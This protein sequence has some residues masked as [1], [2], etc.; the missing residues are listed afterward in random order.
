MLKFKW[1][2]WLFT[3]L[4]Q[5]QIRTKPEC[6]R[7]VAGKELVFQIRTQAGVG[8]TYFI[9]D[10]TIRSV[11]GL[12][13]RPKFTFSFKDAEKGFSTLSARDSQSAFLRALGK[14]QLVIHGD[15]LEV[16]WFQRLTAFL[17]PP[18][19]L[20]PYERTAF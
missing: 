12:V 10:S 6:A 5:R 9:R 13:D 19:K 1:L 14:E 4:L 8:R 20:T 17:Q 16:M 2:L 3:H 11:S 18:K 7:Y 15:F